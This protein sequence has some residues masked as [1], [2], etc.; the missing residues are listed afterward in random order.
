MSAVIKLPIKYGLQA[1]YDALIPDATV[2]YICRDTGNMYLGDKK[3]GNNL[4]FYESSEIPKDIGNIGDHCLTP[5]GIYIKTDDEDN[6]WSIF[7]DWE[8][9]DNQLYS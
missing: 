3:L 5:S 4:L 2:M 1:N 6:P 7:S 8:I 9:K